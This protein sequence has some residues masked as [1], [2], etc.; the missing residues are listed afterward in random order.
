MNI[1]TIFLNKGLFLLAGDGGLCGA[2]RAGR[3]GLQVSQVPRGQEAV[4]RNKVLH[5]VTVTECTK[6]FR[7]SILRLLKYTANLYSIR[8][9]TDLR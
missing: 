1:F 2:G 3:P 5:T 6:I 4:P 9:T 7:K 8:C